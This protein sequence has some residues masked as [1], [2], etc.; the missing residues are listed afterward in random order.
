MRSVT[1]KLVSCLHVD[2][3]NKTVAGMFRISVWKIRQICGS[4]TGHAITGSLKSYQPRSHR[5][6]DNSHTIK[7]TVHDKPTKCTFSYVKCR[8]LFGGR[9]NV[10]QNVLLELTTWICFLKTRV[11]RFATQYISTTAHCACNNCH[12]LVTVDLYVMNVAV[13]RDWTGTGKVRAWLYTVHQYK[14]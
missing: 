10:P 5:K 11:I 6:P 8:D 1:H 14:I 9:Q 13:C 4:E 12:S 7:Q 3:F 2:L